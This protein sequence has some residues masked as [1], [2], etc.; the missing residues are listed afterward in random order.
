MKSI[1]IVNQKGGSGKT[2]FSALLIKALSEEGKTV[3]AIDLDPQGGL[4][5]IL[6]GESE[7]DRKGLFDFLINKEIDGCIHETEAN[8]FNGKI[9]IIP[10]DY[11]TDK[12]ILSVN[13]FALKMLSNLSYDFCILDTPPTVQGI[14]KAGM[15]FAE[16]NII[17]TEISIQSKAPTLYTIESL[18][19]LEK[20]PE[21][22]FS[23]WKDPG[24]K[25][26]YQA[27]LSREFH[28]LFSPYLSGIISRNSTAVSFASEW[29][30]ATPSHKQGILKELNSIMENGK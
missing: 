8:L 1:A 18:K 7:I 12:I 14:S 11:R 27:N 23:G 24:E 19:E 15:I 29:K 16:R 10:S 30:K 3:L 25:G 28:S 20:T 13:P 9:D 4:T 5:S 22:V 6:L 26:G 17:P 2:T 21:V